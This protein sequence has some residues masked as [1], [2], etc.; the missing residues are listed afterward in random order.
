MATQESLTSLTEAPSFSVIMATYNRGRHILP[1]IRSVLWQSCQDLELLIVGDHCTDETEAAVRPLLSN[2]VRWLNRTENSK[3]QSAPNNIGIELAKGRYIAYL[4]HDDIW[5]EDHLSALLS[6]F[7][8][9]PDI[10]FAVSGA[11][12]HMPPGVERPIV[13]GIFSD[14]SSQFTHFFPPSSFAHRRD[15]IERIGGWRQ[16]AEIKPPV[17]AELLLRAAHAGLRFASTGKITAHKFAAGHRYLSYL[18]QTSDEQE[19]ILRRMKEPGFGDHVRDLAELSRRTGNYMIARHRDYEQFE[20][21]QLA[22]ENAVRKGNLR[23]QLRPVTCREVVPQEASACA[24]DWQERQ[25]D[26]LRWV[27]LNPRPKLLIS[28]TSKKTVVVDM[29][30]AHR[31]RE[32]LKALRVLSGDKPIDVR[33][34]TPVQDREHWRAIV[35][36][37][38]RLAA[39]NYTVLELL[40]KDLQIGSSETPGIAVGEIVV[41]P[42]A[43]AWRR[44][45]VRLLGYTKRGSSLVA[46]PPEAG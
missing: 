35:A 33:V 22:K 37:K 42:L 24:W 11:I 3:S 23:P 15:I 21:G 13:T 4:G 7:R 9:D 6:L 26:G 39:D 19:G 36:F 20:P 46:S 34:G 44:V 43:P 10:H 1:S 32:A 18:H 8:A 30:V 29:T 25:P 45:W 40:L 17:D 14:Q 5:S 28:F 2:K 31:R 12:Y 16:P 41:S 38:L 27:G